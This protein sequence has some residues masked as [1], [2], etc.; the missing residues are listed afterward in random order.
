[1]SLPAAVNRPALLGMALAALLPA[2][3][4][5]RAQT[6]LRASGPNPLQRACAAAGVPFPPPQPRL[7]VWKAERRLRLWSGN[8]LL[9]EYPVALGFAPAGRKLRQGDGRTPEG[10]YYLCYR[11]GTSRFHRFLGLSYPGP[12]DARRGLRAGLISRRTARLIRSAGLWRRKPPWDTA[13]GGA[14]GLYGGGVGQDWTWGCVAL[15]ND[16][17]EELYQAL[18][19]GTVIDL[20][21]GGNRGA[22]AATPGG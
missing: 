4:P 7:E 12:E 6:A 10:R 1:M 2:A 14:V 20:R 21:A 8:R 18:P 5:P 19:L 17:I 9:K 11:N 16:A 22:L 13:L 15:T 3:G